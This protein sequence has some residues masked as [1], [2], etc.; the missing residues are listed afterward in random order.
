[1][2]CIL[3]NFQLY[4]LVGLLLTGLEIF[5]PGFVLAPLGLATLAT[6][7]AAWLA[8]QNFTIHAVTFALA[9]L[10]FFWGA[11]QFAEFLTK[12][13]PQDPPNSRFGIEGQ[14]VTLIQKAVDW[15][16]PGRAKLYADEF[17]LL[18]E[19]QIPIHALAWEIGDQLKVKK[20]LG[21]KL[22]VERV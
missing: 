3:E 12:K 15:S 17:D 1:M 20:V 18:W 16:N 21:N 6:S 22:S 2:R 7:A 5:A 13:N 9:T 8:P 4:L 19:D 10:L 14:T 11:R